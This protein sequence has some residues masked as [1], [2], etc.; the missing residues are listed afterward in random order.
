[1][2]KVGE[3]QRSKLEKMT[4]KAKLFLEVQH[5]LGLVHISNKA[6]KNEGILQ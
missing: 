4:L 5:F 2:S 3:E 6:S 1:M